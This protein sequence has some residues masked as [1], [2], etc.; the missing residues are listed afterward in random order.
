[1][2]KWKSFC[3]RPAVSNGTFLI[4]HFQAVVEKLP[5]KNCFMG[6]PGG[7]NNKKQYKLGGTSKQL[8][9]GPHG[10]SVELGAP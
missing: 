10:P 5:W 2:N 9:E 3:D 4:A 7:K 1:M 6:G 8:I